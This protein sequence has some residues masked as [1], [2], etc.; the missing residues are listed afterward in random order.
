[1]FLSVGTSW[2][3]SNS[4]GMPCNG[5]VNLSVGDNC[6]VTITPLTMHSQ[7]SPSATITIK[8]A[9]ALGIPN[10]AISGSGTSSLT[11]NTSLVPSFKSTGML[12]NLEVMV[13]ENG[14]SCWGYVTIEDK[15]PPAISC[16]A[17][18]TVS[19]LV[20]PDAK[21]NPA[22]TVTGDVITTA[23]CSNVKKEGYLDVVQ[24]LKCNNESLVLKRIVRTFSVSNAKG[25][26]STCTQSITVMA[27]D[28]TTLTCPD[29]LV[30]IKC[31]D[32]HTPAAIAALEGDAAA[33]PYVTVGHSN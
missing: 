31:N 16:P 27:V 20:T 14:N 25:L 2:S 11:I 23:A 32:G 15:L 18:M 5:A 9:A 21:G 7:L 29:G 17:D 26:K 33:Y 22:L 10:S 3:Q 30:E 13:T 12:M 28:V 8:N 1:M 24:D 4:P 19:C 6:Q